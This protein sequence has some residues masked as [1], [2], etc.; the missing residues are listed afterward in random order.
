MTSDGIIGA[1]RARPFRFIVQSS[2]ANA[3]RGVSGASCFVEGAMT[4]VNQILEGTVLLQH[5]HFPC[6]MRLPGW[7]IW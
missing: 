5:A 6:H 7:L 1:G 2:F 3:Y 4:L